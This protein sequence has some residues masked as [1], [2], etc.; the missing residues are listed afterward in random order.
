M[1]FSNYFN[2]IYLPVF[3][4]NFKSYDGHLIITEPFKINQ[5]IWNNSLGAIPNSNETLMTLTIGDNIFSDAFAFLN[6]SL[7]ELLQNLYDNDN[8]DIYIH[9]NY[10]KET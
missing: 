3:V 9:L 4:H 8:D 10:M 2:N 6:E 1:Y 5:G 7:D